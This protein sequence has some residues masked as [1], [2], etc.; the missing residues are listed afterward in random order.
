M[1]NPSFP[2]KVAI[3]GAGG[4][5]RLHLGAFKMEPDVVRLTAI[6]DARLEAASALGEQLPYSVPVYADHREMIAN[7][8]LDVAVV[9]LPHYLHFP[10]ARDLIEAGIP[11]LIEKPL[12]CT[13]DET[14]RVQRLA[15]DHGVPVAAG[16]MRRFNREAVWL[17]RWIE[18]NP[19]N[20]GELHSFDIQSWQNIWGWLGR[21]AA[22]DP[23]LLDRERAG[24]GVVISLAV[25][26]LD[27]VRFLTGQDYEEVT[28][29]G[30]FDDPFINGAE[31]SAVV[32][33][34]MSG[35]AA[36]V[37]HASYTTPRTP[38]SEAMS[39]FGKHGTIIQRAEH[40]GQYHGP[41]L[42]ASVSGKETKSWNQMYEDLEQ[43]PEKEVAD[44]HE[45]PFVNQLVFFARAV[46]A[47]ETPINHVDDNFNTMAC[48][49]AIND[50]LRSGTK[51]SVATR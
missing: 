6:C 35:G 17:R 41:F 23:W 4:V 16:Q 2:V 22:T 5:S 33:L 20:F 19:R 15:A 38:Y 21:T 7:A 45:D 31:S 11:T 37:L 48:I 34:K 14:R 40:I 3:I 29:V 13:L 42:Y 46:A 32:L 28:A 39:L 49:Q 43:V 12:T 44:L 8:D 30:R 26:Q 47:G 9:A 50:S 18:D 1:S 27:L 10:I 36:G 24:G 51:E 25:H